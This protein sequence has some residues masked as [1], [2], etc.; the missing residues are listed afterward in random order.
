[1]TKETITDR[2][3]HPTFTDD[4]VLMSEEKYEQLVRL[5]FRLHDGR[6]RVLRK[7]FTDGTMI[8]ITDIAGTGLP[9]TYSDKMRVSIFMFG[10]LVASFTDYSLDEFMALKPKEA[11]HGINSESHKESE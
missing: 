5:G 1:M 11:N 7:N 9:E 6:I 4:G 8:E 3:N 10:N 2:N